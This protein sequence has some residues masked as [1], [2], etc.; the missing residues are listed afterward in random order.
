MRITAN[1]NNVTLDRE[2]TVKELLVELK[3]EAPEYVTVQ[4]NDNILLTADFPTT[5]VKD[6]D[7]VE[8]LYF[9]GGGAR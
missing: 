2:L 3:V 8:F 9:M 6:N 5:I 1:G 4:L 7:A